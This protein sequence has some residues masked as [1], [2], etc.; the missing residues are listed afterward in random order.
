MKELFNLLIWFVFIAGI[1]CGVL[2]EFVVDV[3]TVPTDD[4]LL[5]ASIEPTLHAGDVLIIMK[6]PSVE[7]ANLVR[8]ADPQAAGRFV[9]GRAIARGGEQVTIE[10][11]TI[12]VDRQHVTSPRAC[13]EPVR[14]VF[15]PAQNQ[16]V[17]LKCA[18]QEYAGR[19]YES[20]RS[21]DVNDPPT[22]V[23]VYAGKWFLVSDDRHIHLDSRD[24]GSIDPSHCQ[25]IALRVVGAGGLSDSG[26]RF[27]FI[28]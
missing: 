7:R 27:T 25:R 3:W 12:S 2:Y 13:D 24:F 6:Q 21:T 15:D 23:N 14:S 20:L 28:W 10:T 1:I 11:G 8:C 9:V 17:E 19:E 5:A 18:V 4:P 26:S 22:N 16:N